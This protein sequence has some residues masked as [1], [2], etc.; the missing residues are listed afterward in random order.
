[1]SS[2]V[3]SMISDLEDEGGCEI[4][5]DNKSAL[6]LTN[7]GI[8]STRLL[9]GNFPSADGI[10]PETAPYVVTF[11]TESFIG[12]AEK[13]SVFSTL[14]SK[15]PQSKLTVDKNKKVILSSNSVDYDNSTEEVKETFIFSR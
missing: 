14:D 8:I 10:I 12:I 3:L 1:M 15:G 5:T 13:M 9:I 4:F 2:K 7:R 6:F 11:N